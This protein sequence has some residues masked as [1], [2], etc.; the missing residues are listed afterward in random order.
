M[1]NKI[2]ISILRNALCVIFSALFIGISFAQSSD[3][4]VPRIDVP[5]FIQLGESV[6]IAGTDSLILDEKIGLPKYTWTIGDKDDVK[7]GSTFKYTFDRVGTQRIKLR[8]RQGTETEFTEKDVH[9][10]DRLGILITDKFD[11]KSNL[12]NQYA[13]LISAAAEYG[14]LLD[15]IPFDGEDSNV[16]EETNFQQTIAE[17]VDRLKVAEFIIFE[18]ESP[19]ALN[20]F[21]Q[22][23]RKLDPE[24]QFSVK[25]KQ[26]VQISEGSLSQFYRLI[27]PN[28]QILEMPY[29]LLTR[30]SV[31]SLIFSGKYNTIPT[32]LEARNIEY[33]QVDRRALSSPYFVLTR[34]I[35][36]FIRYGISPNVI[37][38]LLAVPFITF[39][40]GFCRQFIGLKTFGVFAPLML[41]LSLMMLGAK[42]GILAFA[43][44]MAVSYFLR[45]L[46]DRV[47]LL[48]IPKV[49]LLFSAISLSF[50]GVLALA[51]Y[52]ETSLNLALAVFP[53]LVMSTISEKFVSAES[54]T[55]V[56]KAILI[57]AE[58]VLISLAAYGLLELEW[59]KNIILSRPEVIIIPIGLLVWLG[60]FTGLR[61]TE[62]IKFRAL[63]DENSE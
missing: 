23:W 41:T 8:L 63:F 35:N 22:W 56:R 34:M 46:F 18:S 19:N 59:T 6:N 26:I 40:I 13:S 11:D 12:K 47:N 30:S 4:L 49:A 16:S 9:I 5:R 28:V 7:Y 52:F 44:V 45:L 32:E 42:F 27:K 17:K 24:N 21:A 3:I 54:Q 48:Y 50:F 29:I 2:K 62:Y 14:V 31:M 38:L 39:I 10:Y 58:T 55:G 61:L 15:I 51:I 53:L 60:K 57:A 25:T 43:V 33:Y 36:Y 37:Y 1:R 20:N